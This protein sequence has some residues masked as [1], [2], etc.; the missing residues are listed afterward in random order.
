MGS[1]AKGGRNVRRIISE[2]KAKEPQKMLKFRNAKTTADYI[3]LKATPTNIRKICKYLGGSYKDGD[4][5]VERL[6]SKYPN[7]CISRTDSASIWRFPDEAV[8]EELW[9]IEK[10]IS[11]LDAEGLDTFDKMWYWSRQAV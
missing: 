9:S 2:M 7:C 4:Y 8:V 3:D 11:R 5:I 1:R 10:F 6:K